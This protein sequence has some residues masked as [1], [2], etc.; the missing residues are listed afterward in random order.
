MSKFTISL[1]LGVIFS[2]SYVFA[3][4][5]DNRA[6]NDS[7][8]TDLEE[9]SIKDIENKIENLEISII[10][11]LGNKDTL[12]V[13]KTKIRLISLLSNTGYYNKAYELVWEVYPK[14][15]DINDPEL[16]IDIL[17]KTVSLYIKFEQKEKANELFYSNEEKLNGLALNHKDSILLQR[18]I[19]LL[20]ANVESQ[21]N[22]NYPK[23]ETIQIGRAHV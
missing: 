16:Q 12:K 11:D 3:A 13:I 14:L 15:F 8:V 1:F 23:A 2:I 18:R 17:V 19:R 22:K 9:S 7:I 21:L 10:E 20:Q 6:M 4:G 5:N